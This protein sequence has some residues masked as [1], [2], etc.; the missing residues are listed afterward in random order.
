M[1][2]AWRLVLAVVVLIFGGTGTTTADA[3]NLTYDAPIVSRADAH[4]VSLSAFGPTQLR[5]LREG[6]AA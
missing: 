5:D 2:S 6:T 1:V 3:A 4:G